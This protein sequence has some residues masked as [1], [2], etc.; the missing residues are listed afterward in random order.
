MLIT[1][2]LQNALSTKGS[3]IEF[4]SYL[5]YFP[6]KQSIPMRLLYDAARM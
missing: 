4:V 6:D 1:R 5:S 2:R 3:A